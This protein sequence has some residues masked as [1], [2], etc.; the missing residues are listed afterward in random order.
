MSVELIQEGIFGATII[1]NGIPLYL[2]MELLNEEN[3]MKWTQYKNITYALTSRFP[4]S[5][6]IDL[7]NKILQGTMSIDQSSIASSG[8]GTMSIDQDIREDG[9]LLGFT[10]DELT[11]FITKIIN[12]KNP[13]TVRVL[14]TVYSGCSHMHTNFGQK[15]QYI[16]Y[17]SKNPH[18]NIMN[19]SDHPQCTF[20]QYIESYNDILVSMGSNFSKDNDSFEN[21]GIFRNP[22]W[23]LEEKYSG[24]SMLLHGFTGLVA[25][26]FFP[27]KITMNV[28]ALG[29]MQLII[30]QNLLHGEG[31]VYIG[32]NLEGNLINPLQKIDIKDLLV[33][34]DDCQ[35]P[36]N[37]INVEALVRIYNLS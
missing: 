30:Q 8:C 2:R 13:R 32:C 11:I 34:R 5:I 16:V 21:R 1:K 19:I 14:N 15:D 31:V 22:H 20:K 24:L 36:T 23:V 25:T 10:E 6:L 18:F 37:Y 29:G 26:T 4:K 28:S 12:L 9:T 27:T 3:F 17:I 35:G 33:S 7:V